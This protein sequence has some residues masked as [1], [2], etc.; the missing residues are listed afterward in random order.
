[1]TKQDVS[2]TAPP[3]LSGDPTPRPLYQ[4]VKDYIIDHIESGELGPGHRLPSEHELVRTLGVSRMT[5]NRALRELMAQGALTRLPGVGT[6]VAAQRSEAE[7]LRIRSI[8]EEIAGRGRRHRAHVHAVGKIVADDIVA[9][10]LE[11]APETIVFRSVIVHHEDE[12]PIQIEERFVNPE[13]APDYLSVDFTRTTPN[14]YLVRIAP[15][16]EVEHVVEAVL[17][18]DETQRLLRVAAGEPCL[19]LHRRTW[20]NGRIVTAA[21]LTHPGALYRMVARFSPGRSGSQPSGDRVI[22]E[23]LAQ[24]SP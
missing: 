13:Y 6:F 7:F 16:T 8:A 22:R 17:P 12:R 18:D 10:Q 4:R 24:P 14:E 20:S 21:R 2:L 5:A 19:R 11:I 9:G 1:M 15:I 23:Q 3:G